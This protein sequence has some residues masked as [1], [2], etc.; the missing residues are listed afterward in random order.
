M[1]FFKSYP[2]FFN[3]NFDNLLNVFFLEGEEGEDVD[4]YVGLETSQDEAPLGPSVADAS[5]ES[6]DAAGG[7]RHGKNEP[8]TSTGLSG[9]GDPGVLTLER[10]EGSERASVYSGL[11]HD[12]TGSLQQCAEEKSVAPAEIPWGSLVPKKAPKA[13][14][15]ASESEGHARLPSPVE[16]CDDESDL[17]VEEE[18]V[19]AEENV[20]MKAARLFGE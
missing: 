19:F 4:G 18:I 14:P 6:G 15:E 9:G 2:N 17:G 8:L 10:A 5:S 11:A 20:L 12:E 16:N 7:D 1:F 3:L 13:A